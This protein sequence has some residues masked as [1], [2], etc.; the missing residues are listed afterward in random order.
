MLLLIPGR[1]G[2]KGIFI[3]SRALRREGNGNSNI[4]FRPGR[5]L[6]WLSKLCWL[7]KL[8]I[9]QFVCFA[10][11]N[12]CSW[13]D[14][15]FPLSVL[16]SIP[17]CSQT[18][19]FSK[20]LNLQTTGLPCSFFLSQVQIFDCPFS[21]LWFSRSL[22]FSNQLFL[23]FLHRRKVSNFNSIEMIMIG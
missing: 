14:I 17:L 3:N 23:F 4:N 10:L 8:I 5:E 18:Q 6:Y 11:H 1:Q 20:T 15:V 22:Q 19:S 16:Y 7:V 9:L 13:N 2:R 12:F 21:G